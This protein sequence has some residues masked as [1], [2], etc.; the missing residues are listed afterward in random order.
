MSLDPQAQALLDRIE[1][2]GAPAFHTVSPVE[3]RKLYDQASELAKGNPPQPAEV[4][5]IAIPGPETELAARLYRPN[6]VA[7]LPIL[8]YF[9]GGGFPIGSL[10][11]HDVVCRTLCVEAETIVISVDYRLAPEHKYPAA[12]EDAWAATLWA[13]ENAELLG[14]DPTQVGV[15][16]DSAGGTLAAVVG[17]KSV[18]AGSPQLAFQLLIYP[19]MDMSC[20]FPS[21]Q[22]FGQGYRLTTDLINWFYKHYFPLDADF[23]QWQA[24]PL[25]APKE[26]I[27]GLPASFILSAGFDPLQDENKGYTIKLMQEEVAVQFKHYPG[28]IHGFITMP[29]F[30]D[31]AKVALSKCAE[32]MRWGYKF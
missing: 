29:G 19:G 20:S 18:E 26:L 4:K 31:E 1:E 8:V 28:M 7:D 17:L 25:A 14:G 9:H 6:D 32:M 23:M 24:T 11:S 16:G 22:T 2:S 13:V 10:D 30:L 3:A 15:G 12:V 27:K 5:N 21:H